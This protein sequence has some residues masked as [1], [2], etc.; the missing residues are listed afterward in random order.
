MKF[1]LHIGLLGQKSQTKITRTPRPCDYCLILGLW[2]S[3][4]FTSSQDISMIHTPK[5]RT[6][7]LLHFF[8]R[9]SSKFGLIIGQKLKLLVKTSLFFFQKL[10]KVKDF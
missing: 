4:S 6:D 3:K 2:R 8:K 7:L 9:I 10:A 5:E 1:S